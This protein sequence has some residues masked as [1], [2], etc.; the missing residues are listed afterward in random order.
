MVTAARGCQKVSS[1]PLVFVTRY[2]APEAITS[3]LPST[4]PKASSTQSASDMALVNKAKTR[5][6]RKGKDL[7]RWAGFTRAISFSAPMFISKKSKSVYWTLVQYTI[8]ILLLEKRELLRR[9]LPGSYLHLGKMF[10]WTSPLMQRGN[11][12]MVASLF[13]SALSVSG[14]IFLIREMYT[15]YAGMIAISSAPLRAALAHLG[16]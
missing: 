7:S 11:T 9:S 15:P 14:A 10:S 6:R 8:L 4:F 16:Q 12:R 3:I 1:T 13:V 5:A 2:T